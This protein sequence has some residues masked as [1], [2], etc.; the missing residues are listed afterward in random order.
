MREL[1][2]QQRDPHPK[3][4]ACRNA[5]AEAYAASPGENRRKIAA[6]ICNHLTDEQ[7]DSV[8]AAKGADEIKKVIADGEKAKKQAEL[9][10]TA[11]A[12]AAD[13]KRPAKSK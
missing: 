10:A 11:D 1:T 9:Q 2:K 13:K 8:L 12:A 6:G 5:I 4:V 3:L 7:V